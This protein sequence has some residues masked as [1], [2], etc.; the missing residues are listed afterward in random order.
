MIL[1]E[2]NVIFTLLE[3]KEKEINLKNDRYTEF[4]KWLVQEVS[5]CF[6]SKDS[7]DGEDKI[8]VEDRIYIHS[9]EQNCMIDEARKYAN[10]EADKPDKPLTERQ[11]KLM[12]QFNG[13]RKEVQKTQEQILN[14]PL[15]FDYIK[16]ETWIGESVKI[17]SGLY[18]RLLDKQ[19]RQKLDLDELLHE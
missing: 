5:I 15:L 9:A 16:D 6:I 19:E 7:D 10:F 3:R 8:K 17:V 4:F 12:G 13:G 1:F 14:D 11:Q 18:Q 2:K